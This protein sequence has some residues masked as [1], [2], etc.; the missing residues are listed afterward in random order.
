M[1]EDCSGT[2]ACAY[3][4]LK[5]FLIGDSFYR[6]SLSENFLLNV[7]FQIF[8]DFVENEMK[9]GDSVFVIL[10]KRILV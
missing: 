3:F 1:C 9:K 4:E 8:G 7:V 6:L 2:L 5:R 10:G